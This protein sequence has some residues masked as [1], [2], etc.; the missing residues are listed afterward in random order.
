MT[1]H[2]A[3]LFGCF[4]LWPMT[5]AQAESLNCRRAQ[6]TD[7]VTV[8]GSRELRALDLKMAELYA[9]VASRLRGR[10]E[11]RQDQ[12]LFVSKRRSCGGDYSCLESAYLARLIKLQQMET[13]LYSRGKR[14]ELATRLRIATQI[15]RL[16][17]V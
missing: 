4:L 5:T 17:H 15:T 8:C 16:L 2:I 9:D 10:T 7:E 11:L 14:R 12:R 1:Y 3:R 13:E 6:L